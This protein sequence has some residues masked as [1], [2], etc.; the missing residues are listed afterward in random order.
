VEVVIVGG[1]ESAKAGGRLDLHPIMTATMEGSIGHRIGR[2]TIAITAR[3]YLLAK[4]GAENAIAGEVVS[5]SRLLGNAPNAILAILVAKEGVPD[6][7][8]GRE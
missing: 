3:S 4:R 6:A 2:V 5:E 8:L 1:E 7:W